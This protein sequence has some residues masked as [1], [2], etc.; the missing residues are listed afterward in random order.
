MGVQREIDSSLEA[1]GASIPPDVLARL[2]RLPLQRVRTRADLQ[3][4]AFEDGLAALLVD[5]TLL[6]D[7]RFKNA[8][9]GDAERIGRLVRRIAAQGYVPTTPVICRVGRKGK[10]VV[11]DGGHRLTALKAL[12]RR[13]WRVRLFRFLRRRGLVAET[14]GR[15]ERWVCGRPDMIYVILF[16]GR[17]SKV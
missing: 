17:R 6:E 14:P 1:F 12:Y 5:A 8:R 10:W 15:L 4:I 16:L 2:A 9:R 11:V 13:N 7:I 3:G